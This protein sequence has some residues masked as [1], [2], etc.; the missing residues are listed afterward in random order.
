MQRNDILASLSGD[1][2][3]VTL[4]IIFIN[5][6]ITKEIRKQ[7]EKFMKDTALKTQ[8]RLVTR[9]KLIKTKNFGF[10]IKPYVKIRHPSKTNYFKSPRDQY[11]KSN[12]FCFCRNLK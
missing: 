12:I 1:P 11:I 6:L 9:L 8:V 4:N 5:F 10:L 2:L 3:L 7:F